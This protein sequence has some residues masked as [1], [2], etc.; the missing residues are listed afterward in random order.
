MISLLIRLQR[1]QICHVCIKQVKIVVM[2]CEAVRC[3]LN[4]IIQSLSL[5]VVLSILQ[6]YLRIN[7]TLID[8]CHL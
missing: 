2:W 4:E 3:A 7:K 1:T 5:V 6:I 8:L